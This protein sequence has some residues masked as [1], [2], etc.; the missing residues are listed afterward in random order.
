MLSNIKT[1]F[2]DGSADIHKIQAAHCLK[3]LGAVF[4]CKTL[5]KM[6]YL[7]NMS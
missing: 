3:R 4:S 2:S 1:V 5:K 6:V 7:Q